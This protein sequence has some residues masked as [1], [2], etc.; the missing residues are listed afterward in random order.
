MFNYPENTAYVTVGGVDLSVYNAKLSTNYTVSGCELDVDVFQGR[1]RSS[2]LPLAQNFKPLKI[3]LPIDFW[4]RTKV[5][6]VASISSFNKAVSGKF[7]LDLGDGFKYTCI[8]TEFGTPEWITD[9]LCTTNYT[10]LGMRHTA[11]VTI[12][13]STTIGASVE[14]AST[15]PKTDCIITLPF[16]QMGGATSIQ[17]RLGENTW[18]ISGE[19]T[20][21][22]VLDGV[23][24]IYTMGGKNITA[25]VLW[26]DFPYLV[27]GS[28]AISLGIN[29]V[30]VTKGMRVEYYPTY[31]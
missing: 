22:I 2:L 23:N 3:V 31:L 17:V 29:G 18:G 7:E 26:T 14:C 27:P 12:S 13:E 8:C 24:K 28:N 4:G 6:T 9:Q 19:M 30:S 11:K 10:F 1:N 25:N 20:A 15:F 21:D 5:V 16:K